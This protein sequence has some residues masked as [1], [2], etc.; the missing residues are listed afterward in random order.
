MGHCTPQNGTDL[1]EVL[2][3]YTGA[4]GSY[5]VEGACPGTKTFEDKVRMYKYLAAALSKLASNVYA[6]M[7]V[8]ACTY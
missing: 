4:A 5:Q 3:G 1:A 2:V 6:T 7:H 8:H